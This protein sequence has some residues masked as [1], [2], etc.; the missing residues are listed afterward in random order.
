MVVDA[1]GRVVVSSQQPLQP[2]INSIRRPV[3]A[4]ATGICY[5][6]LSTGN[7]MQHR[8]LITR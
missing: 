6:Q 5:L 1:A 2:G 8:A 3:R 7:E 4:V